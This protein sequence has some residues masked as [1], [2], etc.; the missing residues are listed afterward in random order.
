MCMHVSFGFV[1]FVSFCFVLHVSFGFVM[2]VSI[3]MF[4]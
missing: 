1:M 2:Y 4:R 3:C